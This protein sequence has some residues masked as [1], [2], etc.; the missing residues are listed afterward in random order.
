[1]CATPVPQGQS[2]VAAPP[3]PEVD[4]DLCFIFDDTEYFCLLV[5]LADSCILDCQFSARIGD[6]ACGGHKLNETDE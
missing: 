2:S 3:K 6:D 5:F 4:S 1:M